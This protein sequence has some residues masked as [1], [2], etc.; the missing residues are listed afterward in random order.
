M[1]STATKV[2]KFPSQR[3][4]VGG[5]NSAPCTVIIMPVVRIERGPDLPRKVSKKKNRRA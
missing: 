3:V 4:R 2:V 1:K 5:A